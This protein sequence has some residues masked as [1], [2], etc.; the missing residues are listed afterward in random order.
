MA[1]QVSIAFLSRVALFLLTAATAMVTA[2]ALSVEER[3][4]LALVAGF[5]GLLALL[6]GCGVGHAIVYY[7]GRGR[8]A[9]GTLALTGVT[10]GLGLGG[11]GIV[12][13][14]LVYALLPG[15]FAGV[16]LPLLWLALLVLPLSLAETNLS[17]VILGLQH[18]TPALLLDLLS[19]A[20]AFLLLVA[21]LPAAPYAWVALLLLTS[22]SLFRLLAN[23]LFFKRRR[24]ALRATYDRRAFADTLSYGLRGVAG[25]LL[26]FLTLRL[27]LFLV[28]FFAGP[29]AVG[30]Y[31]IAVTAAEALWYLSNSIGYV[32]WPRVANLDAAPAA[33]ATA[34]ASRLALALTVPAA[35][36]LAVAAPRLIP[37]VF[38]R[39]YAA[40]VPAVLALLPGIVAFSI[41]NVMRNYIAGRGLPLLYSRIAALAL[42][43]A[44]L[45]DLLLIPAWGIV[46]AGAATSVSYLVAAA[47]ALL[48][49]RRLATLPLAA[50]LLPQPADL[51]LLRG[52]VFRPRP[53]RE[54]GWR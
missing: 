18:V 36:L 33:I 50:A 19:R 5:G 3:G 48:A 41:A 35:A 38:G 1:R 53:L 29:L 30:H 45:L 21:I 54:R 37:A 25:A 51:T 12:A 15:P 11:L 43:V 28:N 27:D 49:Y 26:E 7:A 9:A 23:L 34:R 42:L 52:L 24:I 22:A 47:S 14:R 2:R 39:E 20:L 13:G 16:E 10:L 4:L 8:H 44:L 31:A 32:L 6:F 17:Y 40:A 46:G